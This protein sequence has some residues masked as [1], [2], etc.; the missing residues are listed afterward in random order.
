[1]ATNEGMVYFA[2]DGDD[3]EPDLLTEFLGVT[4]TSIMRKGSRIPDKVPAKNSWVLSTENIINDYIDVFSMADSI[5]TQLEPKK[6]VVIEAIEKF[7]LYPRLEVVI[8]FSMNEDHPTPVIGFEPTTIKFLGDV[9]AFVDI[10]TYK[11]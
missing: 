5:I 2:L 8:W 4:P 11:H 7:Q 9:G 1:M 6:L 10:D 3:F